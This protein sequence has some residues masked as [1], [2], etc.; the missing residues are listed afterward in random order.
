VNVSSR[1]FTNPHFVR[2]VQ[3]VLQSTGVNPHRLKLEITESAAMEKVNEVI[4]KMMT[5]KALGIQISLDDFGTGYSSLS[6]L[7]RLSLDQLKIDKSFVRDVLDGV[8]DASIVRT[9]IDLGRNLNLQEFAIGI[10]QNYDGEKSEIAVSYA[11]E[12]PLSDEASAT[13]GVP[14]PWPVE[15]ICV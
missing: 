2:L 5:L 8:L 7:K 13:S 4:E 15:E 12:M 9:I 14:E 3:D 6:Q 11:R 10:R 1:Q